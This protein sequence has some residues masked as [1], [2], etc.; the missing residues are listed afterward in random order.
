M[1]LV[2]ALLLGKLPSSCLTLPQPSCM[3]RYPYMVLVYALLYINLLALH[4]CPA[5]FA[6]TGTPTWCWCVPCYTLTF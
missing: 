4:Q 5:S 2:C 1:M 6:I 3:H